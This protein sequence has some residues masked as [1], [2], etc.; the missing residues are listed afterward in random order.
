[1]KTIVGFLLVILTAFTGLKAQTVTA[2]PQT[3]ALIQFSGVVYD[4]DSLTPIPFVS[5][6]IKGTNRGTIC[7]F[8]GFFSLIVNPGDE[9]EFHSVSH[10]LRTYKIADTLNQKY[11]YA[12][13]LLTK[14]TVQLDEVSVYPWPSK[15]DFKRAFLALD[16]TDTDMDRADKN[17]QKE[18]LT[19]LERNQT[20]SASENYKYVM[21]AYY[22]KV[23]TTG[24]A[25]SMT[26]L[27]PV[28]WAQ[29]IDAWRKGKFSNKKKKN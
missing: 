28:A 20:A 24:Q 22:T 23:Y 5:I 27:N 4:Q 26:L 25:P 10:K 18:A 7:G 6:L 29:F 16:L 13:Q 2:K 19:Y 9:L 11:Y 1:M 8:S 3:A 12:I 15:E 17:L 14:D 21:Q